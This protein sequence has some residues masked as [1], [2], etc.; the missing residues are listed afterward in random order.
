MLIKDKQVIGDNILKRRKQR[1][2]TQFE[3]AELAEISDRTYA[4][5]ERGVANMRVD[6][7]IK[8]CDALKIT[9]NDILVDEDTYS[10]L[11][12]NELLDL[13]SDCSPREKKTACDI[14]S[15]LLK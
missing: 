12:E 11:T 15:I 13:I 8:I 7:L 9:P 4:D 14:L 2:L 1:G 5:I 3:T 6:T 10:E